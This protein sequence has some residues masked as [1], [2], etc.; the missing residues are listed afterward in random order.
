MKFEH[1]RGEVV[2]AEGVTQSSVYRD[3]Q[4]RLASETS[5]YFETRLK[6]PQGVR[7]VSLTTKCAEGD[8]VIVLWANGGHVADANLTTGAY[9]WKAPPSSWTRR[10][11]LSAIAILGVPLVIPTVGAGIYYLVSKALRE[12]AVKAEIMKLAGFS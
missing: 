4:G 2:A 8:D 10:G 11:I 5:R 3:G 7:D 1:I 9:N 12:N 6:T